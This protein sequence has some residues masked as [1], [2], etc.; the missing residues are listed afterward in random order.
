MPD[1]LIV[2]ME[3]RAQVTQYVTDRIAALRLAALDNDIEMSSTDAVPKK[4][5]W[6]GTPGGFQNIS[7]L[8]SNAMKFLPNF[9]EKAQLHTLF[10]LFPD[11]HF[12]ARKHKARIISPTLLAEYAYVLRVGGIV[13]TVTD[14]YDLHNWMV[15]HLD[16]FPLFKRIDEATLREQGKGD[17]VDAV[18]N[19]TE[20]GQKVERN[21]GQKY[22]AAFIRIEDEK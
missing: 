13:Y 2:G 4:N 22:F 3:I 9:F 17:I 6:A 18:L 14:V 20:E 15:T 21:G 8:R 7:V 1:T 11:P 12:K 5:I 10:F 19:G 16:A